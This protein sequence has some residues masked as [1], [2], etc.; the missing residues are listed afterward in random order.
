[1][2]LESIGAPKRREHV[3]Q[4]P[5]GK[6]GKRSVHEPQLD[7]DAGVPRDDRSRP[8]TA[9]RLATT[10]RQQPRVRPC[11]VKLVLLVSCQ[12]GNDIN[13]DQAQWEDDEHSLRR[14]CQFDGYEGTFADPASAGQKHADG[15]CATIWQRQTAE[16]PWPSGLG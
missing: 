7:G 10:L 4:P 1:M 11:S 16:V 2:S 15:V 9:S 14:A 12:P 8:S 5:S 3:V 13:H 6:M